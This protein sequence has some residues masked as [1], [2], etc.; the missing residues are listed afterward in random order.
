MKTKI[1]YLFV[2]GAIALAAPPLRNMDTA[3]IGIITVAIGM[4]V[5]GTIFFTRCE[6]QRDQA[7]AKELSQAAM[8]SGCR[9]LPTTTQ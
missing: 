3:T 9:L 6:R 2:A 5:T 4:M 7:K 8:A 1:T